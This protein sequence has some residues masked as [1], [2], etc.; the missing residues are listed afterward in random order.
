M[1]KMITTQIAVT[2]GRLHAIVPLDPKE[3]G[4]RLAAARRRRH[5]TQ[6]EFALKIKRSPAS[7][8]RWERGYL[9]PVRE[10]MRIAD[11]LGVEP[12][13]LVEEPEDKHA[14]LMAR[15]DE[16]AELHDPLKELL[17]E[18]RDEAK[19]RRKQNSRRKR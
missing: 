14:A 12:A 2:D 6:L 8:S 1:R 18:L 11:V 3:V 16:L 9:P 10:L 7:V 13:E 4:Q 15:L 5:W 17:A 19:Q